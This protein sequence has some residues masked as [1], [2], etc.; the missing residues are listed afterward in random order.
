MQSNICF[1]NILV[2]GAFGEGKDGLQAPAPYHQPGWTAPVSQD[3][4]ERKLGTCHCPTDRSERHHYLQMDQEVEAGKH[5]TKQAE[6]GKIYY[7][8]KVWK[9]IYEIS[10]VVLYLP[11]V[12]YTITVHIVWIVENNVFYSL[13]ENL[14]FYCVYMLVFF[15]VLHV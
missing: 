1:F 5:F 14:T 13:W 10:F 2:W 8:R 9:G 4:A 11:S 6:K 12:S 7:Q 15:V 3:V